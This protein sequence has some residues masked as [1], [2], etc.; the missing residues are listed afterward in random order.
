MTFTVASL[1][2]SHLNT[3]D[4][5]SSNTYMIDINKLSDSWWLKRLV[6]LINSINE[7]E[8]SLVASLAKQV[9]DLFS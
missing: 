6:Y 9:S 8:C 7:D 5:L 1:T 2:G 3:C 4:D